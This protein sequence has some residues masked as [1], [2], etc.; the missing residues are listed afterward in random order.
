MARRVRN[1]VLIAVLL[2]VAGIAT[3]LP[4]RSRLLYSFDSVNFALGME[5]FNLADHQPHP[6]GYIVYVAL[7]RVINYFVGDANN[8]L[9]AMSVIAGAMAVVMIYFIASAIFDQTVGKVA[10]VLLLFSPL[11]WFYSEIALSYEVALPLA[12]AVTWFLYQLY[13]FRRGATAAAIILGLAAGVRQDLL[14]FLGPI[15]FVGTLRIGRR[16]MLISWATL[17]VAAAAWFTPLIYLTGG[18]SAYL[19]VGKSQFNAGV[20]PTSIFEMGLRGIAINLKLIVGAIVWLLGAATVALIYLVSLVSQPKRF[21]TDRRVWF[22]VLTPS[23]ALA[24][25]TFFLFD[26]A[27][28]LLVYSGTLIIIGARVISLM[29]QDAEHLRRRLRLVWFLPVFLIIVA[30]ANTILF[31]DTAKFDWHIPFNNDTIASTFKVYSE[32]E[33]TQTVNDTQL[34]LDAVREFDPHKTMVVGIN[35]PD[36]LAADWRRLLYY[37]PE[38]QTV[39]LLSLPDGGYLVTTEHYFYRKRGQKQ[40]TVPEDYT[41]VL[42]VNIEPDKISRETELIIDDLPGTSVRSLKMPLTGSVIAEDYYLVHEGATS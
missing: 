24:F 11:S 9:V 5:R 6:P 34:I 15:W 12:L 33:V 37:L 19:H 20:Q 1:D 14:L 25:F 29:A 28:Y 17:I 38:Y 16:M 40:V 21:Y 7:A 36:R 10:A 39:W 18:L 4:F 32:N 42:F 2:F 26:P 22:L 41:D 27:G 30:A 31:T 35:P 3:R 13:F 23:L 8:T